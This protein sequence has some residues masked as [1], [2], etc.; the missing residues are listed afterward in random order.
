MAASGALARSEL[1]RT[2]KG[3]ST[4]LPSRRSATTRTR[5]MVRSMTSLTGSCT[6]ADSPMIQQK[7]APPWVRAQASG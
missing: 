6:G 7:A 1:P 2:S 3:I 4:T 5:F